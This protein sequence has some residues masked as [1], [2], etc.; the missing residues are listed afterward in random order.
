MSAEDKVKHPL[1]ARVYIWL[2]RGRDPEVEHR[3]ALVAGLQ[4]RVIEVGAGNGLN[5]PHYPSGVSQ[6]L[7]VEPEPILREAAAEAAAEAP[8]AIEVVDGTAANL[9]AQEGEFDAGIASLV[10][11]SVPSQGD[12]LAELRRV[13]RPGGEFRFYEHVV[14]SHPRRAKMM[15]LADRTFWPRIAGNCHLARATQAAI[16][17]AGFEIEEVDRFRFSPGPPVP[18]L[19][20]IRGRARRP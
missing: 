6:V 13:I 20:H 2:S 17:G 15:R 5:F 16:E 11:C 7:A 10:L 12:A 8:V 18:S 1:F 4:G 14:S 9:P 3:R 19:P